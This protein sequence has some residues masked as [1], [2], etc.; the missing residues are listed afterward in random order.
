MRPVFGQVRFDVLVH[1]GDVVD[2]VPAARDPG[3]VG[4]DGDG[5]AGPVERGDGIR[6]PVDELDAVDRA[7]VPVVDDYRAVAIKQNARP[8]WNL[9]H[10][11][12]PEFADPGA[13]PLFTR[14]SNR[15]L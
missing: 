4:D 5:D 6:R 3:L 12:S 8:Y 13:S 15:R 1:L 10:V 7:H 2:P 14:S 9:C 11:T